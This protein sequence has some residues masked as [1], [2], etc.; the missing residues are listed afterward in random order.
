MG[1]Q[2]TDEKTFCKA[3]GWLTW[4]DKNEVSFWGL[5][6]LKPLKCFPTLLRRLVSLKKDSMVVCFSNCVTLPEL[7]S[8]FIKRSLWVEDKGCKAFV[9]SQANEEE[10]GHLGNLA[11]SLP[12]CL[13]TRESFQLLLCHYALS[14]ITLTAFKRSLKLGSDSKEDLPKGAW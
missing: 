9:S 6:L 12:I 2:Q 14:E 11:P 5:W 10:A 1:T 3:E 8:Q 7:L 13:P 4:I